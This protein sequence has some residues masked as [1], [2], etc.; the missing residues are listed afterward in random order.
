M[1]ARMVWLLGV[2]QREVIMGQKCTRCGKDAG[3]DSVNFGTGRLCLSCAK[4]MESEPSK[5]PVCGTVFDVDDAVAMLL[6]RATATP[7]ERI[8]AHSAL[9]QVCPKC[10]IL[11]FDNFQ[12]GLLEGLK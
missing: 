11:F 10:H 6:T 1:H 12:Y 4:E 3:A 5:C 2:V 7:Q 9:I 8:A